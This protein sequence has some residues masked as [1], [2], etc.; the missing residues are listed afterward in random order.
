MGAGYIL[1]V[2]AIGFPDYWDVGCEKKRRGEDDFK[3]F[4]LSV[5]T[6]GLKSA[7]MGKA[8]GRAGLVGKIRNSVLTIL[9]LKCLLDIQVESWVGSYITA[10][11]ITAQVKLTE[12]SETASRFG[13]M[14]PRPKPG[15][16]L[17][18]GCTAFHRT[19][20][21][22]PSLRCMISEQRLQPRL[23]G[24]FLSVLPYTVKQYLRVPL[25]FLFPRKLKPKT[26]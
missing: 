15:T 10:Q 12:S 4:G 6:M 9:S 19:A 21:W 7:E 20:A 14:D 13:Q 3:D 25:Y 24:W 18:S 22:G 1:Q 16:V 8:V 23:P 17:S 11:R 26:S 5:G 2:N